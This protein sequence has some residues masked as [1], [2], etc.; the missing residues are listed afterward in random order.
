MR[1]VCVIL[2]AREPRMS[3]A[4]QAGPWPSTVATAS[5]ARPVSK[6]ATADNSTLD[7]L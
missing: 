3:F 5:E 6:D 4:Q 7:D 1:L 2:L